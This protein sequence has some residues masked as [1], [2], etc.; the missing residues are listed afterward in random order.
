MASAPMNTNTS[1]QI[2]EDDV[3]NAARDAANVDTLKQLLDAAPEEA[4]LAAACDEETG[5][6]AL[7]IS[8]SMGHAE[9]VELLLERGGVWNAQDRKGRTA[10]EHAIDAEYYAVAET[11]LDHAVCCELILGAAARRTREAERNEEN[12]REREE[13]YLRGAVKYVDDD[14]DGGDVRLVDENN[15]GV[16]MAWEAPI[17]EAH[18]EA[19]MAS[20]ATDDDEQNGLAILNVGYGLGLIDKAIRR[21]KPRVHAIIEAHPD[22]LKRM[23]KDGF[24]DG[25][26]GVRVFPGK[27]QD[28]IAAATTGLL[29][30]DE[31]FDCIFFDTYGEYYHDMADFHALLPSLLKTG[32]IYSFFNG[33]A[34]DNIFFQAVYARIIELELKRMDIK[35]EFVRLEIQRPEGD[36]WLG[37][38][39]RYYYNDYY[40]MPLCRRLDVQEEETK[41]AVA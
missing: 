12:V 16:M 38:R 41:Q 1:R 17:M 4:N 23:Q 35:A 6:T 20:A 7:M 37:V 39:Q 40:Y 13:A 30:D 28:V 14:T 3:V 26:R 24:V 29:G 10:G 31:K 33:L 36:T 2:T 25:A 32:G 9:A 21:R 19:M 11:I 27:W 5:V 8:A 18:A 34:P 22:V 15:D